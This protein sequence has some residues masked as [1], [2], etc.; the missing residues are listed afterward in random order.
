[1][2][3]IARYGFLQN[4]VAAAFLALLLAL[5]GRLGAIAFL[6]LLAK[7]YSNPKLLSSYF[8]KIYL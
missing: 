8:P 6:T 7:Q 2:N 3:A 4:K 5:F 1:M